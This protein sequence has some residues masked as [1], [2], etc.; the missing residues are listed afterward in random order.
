MSSVGD[1]SSEPDLGTWQSVCLPEWS[2]YSQS[3]PEY[4]NRPFA[5]QVVLAAVACS[6]KANRLARG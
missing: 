2:L 5:S 6:C 3:S 4:D 1:V